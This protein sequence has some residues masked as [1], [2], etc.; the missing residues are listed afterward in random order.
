MVLIFNN[1]A[2][3]HAYESEGRLSAQQHER[4]P[5]RM[6]IIF[7]FSPP[8]TLQWLQGGS[9]CFPTRRNDC[10]A[11]MPKKKKCYFCK[12]TPTECG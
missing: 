5:K 6:K 4:E 12:F 7:F 1:A 2:T 8:P 11:V 9:T 3:C 10:S